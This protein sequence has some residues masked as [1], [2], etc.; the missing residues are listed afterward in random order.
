MSESVDERF[1][2]IISDSFD[3]RLNAYLNETETITTAHQAIIGTI[4]GTSFGRVLLFNNKTNEI[5]NEKQ[6]FTKD[7]VIGLGYDNGIIYAAQMKGQIVRIYNEFKSIQ[8]EE[9]LKSNEKILG[10][11]MDQQGNRNKKLFCYGTQI[12][13]NPPLLRIIDKSGYGLFGANTNLLCRNCNKILDI[14]WVGNVICCIGGF[15]DGKEYKDAYI[16]L[17][18]FSTKSKEFQEIFTFNNIKISK[19]SYCCV[20]PCNDNRFIISWGQLKVNIDVSPSMI[21]ESKKRFS[22]SMFQ[23]NDKSISIR[24][25]ALMENRIIGFVDTQE[26]KSGLKILQ[27]SS[28]NEPNALYQMDYPKEQVYLFGFINE[29]EK[30]ILIGKRRIEVGRMRKDS[31]TIQLLIQKKMFGDILN[32]VSTSKEKFTDKGDIQYFW[33]NYILQLTDIKDESLIRLEQHLKENI[34]DQSDIVAI[35]GETEDD[36]EKNKYIR[37]FTKYCVKYYHKL[38]KGYNILLSAKTTIIPSLTT[39]I[40]TEDL[41][42]SFKL[43]EDIEDYKSGSNVTLNEY[44]SIINN[45]LDLYNEILL[46]PGLPASIQNKI[47]NATTSAQELIND[48]NIADFQGFVIQFKFNNGLYLPACEYALK[49]QNPQ[50]LLFILTLIEKQPKDKIKEIVEMFGNDFDSVKMC[51][52]QQDTLNNYIIEFQI[53]QK[54]FKLFNKAMNNTIKTALFESISHQIEENKK[55]PQLLY[56][57]VSGR[58]GD[59]GQF[60]IDFIKEILNKYIEENGNELNFYQYDAGV[61]I[62]QNVVDVIDKKNSSELARKVFEEIIKTPVVGD[63]V[64]PIMLKRS[65]FKVQLF[66]EIPDTLKIGDISES[67][68]DML[69]SLKFTNHTLSEILKI[70]KEESKKKMSKASNKTGVTFNMTTL[71]SKCQK[72]LTGPVKMFYCGHIYHDS[73]HRENTCV[74][75]SMK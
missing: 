22:Q 15:Y 41:A 68:R 27:S 36:Q 16:Y 33:K 57:S 65:Q 52:P 32:R 20:L 48:T 25:M 56:A 60:A 29:V 30:I 63:V 71:C 46:F 67:V 70:A 43:K 5:V 17:Y 55:G 53:Y 6:L 75:C 10:F 31:D 59:M 12:G 23:V 3:N 61:E 69:C 38:K 35:I 2:Y 44:T 19:E 40:I 18:D 14:K 28:G 51:M 49:T 4:L 24:S 74:L 54:L 13:N 73:C 8:S 11:C 42:N 47:G 58:I 7:A 39:Q 26:G 1:G 50:T 21:V 9:E 62:I 66:D 64:I 72:P 37:F 34:I 45:E